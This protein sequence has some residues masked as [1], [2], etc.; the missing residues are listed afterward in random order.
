MGLKTVIPIIYNALKPIAVAAS[1]ALGI[2]IGN[3]ELTVLDNNS[4]SGEDQDYTFTA[5][6]P[7]D[8]SVWQS[9]EEDYGNED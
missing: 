4:I 5:A 2:I 8:Y 6:T 9:F 3:G 1:I 7:S